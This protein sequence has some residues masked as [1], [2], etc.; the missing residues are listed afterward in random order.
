MQYP[1]SLQYLMRYRGNSIR[2]LWYFLY[3]P[4]GEATSDM[5][6]NPADCLTGS[7]LVVPLAEFFLSL[8]Q[9]RLFRLFILAGIV[10]SLSMLSCSAQTGEGI[11]GIGYQKGVCDGDSIP[12]IMEAGV[13]YPVTISFRNSGLAVWE[14]GR[15][16]YELVLVSGDGFFMDP[17]AVLIPQEITITSG[18]SYLFACM[19][20][21]PEATGTYPVIFGMQVRS[22]AQTHQFPQVYEKE[23]TVIPKGGISSPDVGSLHIWTTPEGATVSLNQTSRGTTPVIIPDLS[24]G[25]YRGNLTLSGFPTRSFTAEV[26]PGTIT[27]ITLDL[28]D[29]KSQGVIMQKTPDASL[30]SLL[31]SHL[32]S[33]II[34]VVLVLSALVFLHLQTGD[35]SGRFISRRSGGG[36]RIGREKNGSSGNRDTGLSS[37]K[38]GREGSISAEGFIK[39]EAGGRK[40]TQFKGSS[41]GKEEQKQKG[42]IGAKGVLDRSKKTGE[43]GDAR[44]KITGNDAIK[45]TGYENELYLGF[46]HEL[47]DRYDPLALIGTDPYTRVYQVR[48]KADEKVRVV[49]LPQ[50]REAPSEILEKEISVW[51]A[52]KHPRILPIYRFE[53]EPVMYLE[54]EYVDGVAVRNKTIHSFAEFKK[55]V[56]R[57]LAVKLIRGVAE[58]IAF[59]HSQGVRHYHLHQG[60]I[61]L[62]SN[63]EPVLTGLA[64]GKNEF[65]FAVGDSDPAEAD[66]PYLAPEQRFPERYGPVGMKTDIFQVG[67]ILYE[68]LTGAPPYSEKAS[69]AVGLTIRSN[70]ELILPSRINPSLAPFDPI[71]SRMLAWEK[72]DRY[73]SI[74]DFLRDLDLLNDA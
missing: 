36:S 20:Q 34:M 43:E 57:R 18:K 52:M 64:R 7:R 39:E 38:E 22:G 14:E 33:I 6:C 53:Y 17:P 16:H 55:P 63:R 48:R 65:G 12:G 59:L 50:N 71:L 68:L 4:G 61:L 10:L 23:I 32:H 72:K 15:E 19:L 47:R 74:M 30:V 58:G 40:A 46:P 25:M 42:M 45:E 8:V 37:G 69:A 44:E 1:G 28:T 66:A 62:D 9:N 3:E 2:S 13:I 31:L 11:A 27:T 26:V 35:R 5:V 21:A 67:A 54:M 49:K 56:S 73:R 29:P 60:N 51:H 41:A 70:E 24:P